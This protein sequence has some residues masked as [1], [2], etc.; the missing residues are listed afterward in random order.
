M[1]NNTLQVEVKFVESE[2]W[3]NAALKRRIYAILADLLCNEID[4]SEES[5]NGRED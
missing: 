2:S 4:N 3:V 5:K 1:K